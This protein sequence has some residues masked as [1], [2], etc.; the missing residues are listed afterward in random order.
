MKFLG[1]LLEVL[2]QIFCS[3]VDRII[4]FVLIL[5]ILVRLDNFVNYEVRE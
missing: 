3:T 4:I 1:Y 5:L 2:D